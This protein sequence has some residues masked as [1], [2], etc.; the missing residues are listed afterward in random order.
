MSSLQS[1]SVVPRL[2]PIAVL[3][4]IS[5]VA[6]VGYP[7]ICTGDAEDGVTHG[8]GFVGTG[9][10]SYDDHTAINPGEDPATPSGEERGILCSSDMVVD[11]TITN[12]VPHGLTGYAASTLYVAARIAG[13]ASMFSWGTYAFG[14]YVSGGGAGTAQWQL[15]NDFAGGVPLS[16]TGGAL[17]APGDVIELTVSGTSIVGKLNGS[18]ILSA[19]DS[20]VGSSLSGRPTSYAGWSF[21]AAASS[22][23]SVSVSATAIC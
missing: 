17:P 2:V 23:V 22:D 19:T 1:R 6:E 4:S 5:S 15:Y 12:L 16:T 14:V 3:P 20:L 9:G 7:C 18:T 11:L 10:Q 21:G 13:P 8:S